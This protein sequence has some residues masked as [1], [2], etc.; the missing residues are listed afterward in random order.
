MSGA[1]RFTA[2]E[3]SMKT[4][5]DL[6]TL[7]KKPGIGDAWWCWCTF[8]HV[9]SLSLI[10]NEP[11]RARA[12]RAVRNHREMEKLV[13]TGES[14]G[15]IVYSKEGEPIGWCQYGSSEELPRLDHSRNYK[16]APPSDETKKLWRITCFVIDRNYRRQG[17]ATF[18]LKAALDAITK[19]GGG[20]V[21]A[22]PVD[23]TDQGP[24]YMY[25]G[26]TS[27]FERAGFKAVAPFGTGRTSSVLMRKSVAG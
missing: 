22:I 17:L 4:W 20:I 16:G 9:S 19:E 1:S 7:F 12:E 15:I 24:G 18:A 3:L 2:K 21:E 11:P 13:E 26:R 25:T 5:P 8:H 23:K 14:H 10:E 27:T 6:E